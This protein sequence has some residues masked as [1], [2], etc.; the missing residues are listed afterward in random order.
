MLH[1]CKEIA[2]VDGLA[3]RDNL[4]RIAE[5][6]NLSH[7]L[8]TEH[9]DASSRLQPIGNQ[10]VVIVDGGAAAVSATTGTSTFASTLAAPTAAATG[11][12]ADA[13]KPPT[14]A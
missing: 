1:A 4:L 3:V 2:A 9:V 7:T 10:R 6:A 5:V 8:D 12:A 14:N 11:F 13:G